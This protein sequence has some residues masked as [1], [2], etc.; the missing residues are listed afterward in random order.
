VLISG[1]QPTVPLDLHADQAVLLPTA[2]ALTGAGCT[3][4]TFK[5]SFDIPDLTALGAGPSP[6]LHLTAQTV[7]QDNANDPLTASWRRP[8]SVTDGSAIEIVLDGPDGTDLDLFLY[9]DADG[10]GLPVAGEQ[11]AS[12]GSSQPDEYIRMEDPPD[13][14]YIVTVHGWSVPAGS[15]TFDLDLLVMEGRRVTARGLPASV[16]AGQQL[17]FEV[18]VEM[19]PG[20]AP[21]RYV[22]E[23]GLG[24]AQVPGL[25]KVPVQVDLP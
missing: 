7:N 24:P 15:T 25:L 20:A 16:T 3:P 21:G 18:C 14:D 23:F 8:F 9:R 17:S 22:G 10:D 12:S 1:R 4:A 19:T 11:V 6:F 13:G 2:V 5:P